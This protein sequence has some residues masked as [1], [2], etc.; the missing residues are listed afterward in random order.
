VLDLEVAQ[1][2][3]RNFSD[4]LPSKY[5]G[6]HVGWVRHFVEFCEN[7][8][9]SFERKLILLDRQNFSVKVEIFV[10]LAVYK[11]STC[12]FASMKKNKK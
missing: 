5:A 12:L 7:D 2:L 10:K 9:L 1:V 4:F 3:G 8:S 6:L 11:N